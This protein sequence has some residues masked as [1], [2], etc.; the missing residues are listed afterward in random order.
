VNGKFAFGVGNPDTNVQS[1]GSITN[2][3]W[4]HVAATRDMTTGDITVIINGV[5]DGTKTTTQKSSLTAPATITLG[6]D[7]IDSHYFNGLIDELRLWNVVRTPA[8]IMGTMH[9]R[10]TGN[11]P[12]LVGYYRFDEGTGTT[13]Q[14][15]S[16]THGN[17]T[18]TSTDAGTPPTWVTSDAPVCP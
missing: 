16:A 18:L 14:D 6:A 2:G 4:T 10:L 3:Q 12:G 9:Q 5:M 13:A 1:A 11:E 15:R 8:D 7:T 17:V